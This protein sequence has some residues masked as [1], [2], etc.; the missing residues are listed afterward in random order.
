MKKS[1]IALVVSATF[2]AACGGSDNKNETPD[3][4]ES[5]VLTADTAST[6]NG[7]SITIDVLANDSDPDGDTLTISAVGTPSTGDVTIVDNALVYSPPAQAMGEIT[8]S[9]DVTC[10]LY[11]SPSPR[12]RQKS[13]MP[14]SA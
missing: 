3:L 9:Y 6:L 2:L 10:L 5:P 13:R 14:S 7:E 1:L 8:F 12:D 11:T 4:N